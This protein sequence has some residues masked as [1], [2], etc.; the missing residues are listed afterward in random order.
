M[1]IESSCWRLSFTELADD[2]WSQQYDRLHHR[3]EL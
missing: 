1:S 2:S 3:R